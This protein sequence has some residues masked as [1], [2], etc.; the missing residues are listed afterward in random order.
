[1]HD[2]HS[3]LSPRQREV[4]DLIRA[5]VR[6]VREAPPATLIARRLGLHHSTVAS[7]LQALADK[8][9]LSSPTTAGLIDR[10]G[11]PLSAGAGGTGRN[12]RLLTSHD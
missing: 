2:D 1:M 7:H 4:L 3:T 12:T 5:H 6:L 11:D 10:G 9:Y 8:G